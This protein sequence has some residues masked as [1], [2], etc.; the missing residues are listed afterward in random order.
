MEA[1]GGGDLTIP[2]V[3]LD[4]VDDVVTSA[5]GNCSK[6]RYSDHTVGRPHLKTV[7]TTT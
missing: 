5:C 3:T 4:N 1:A 7:H 6:V 2:V